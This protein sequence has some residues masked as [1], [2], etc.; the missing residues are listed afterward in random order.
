MLGR[1][2]ELSLLNPR[3][4]EPPS[5]SLSWRQAL[6]RSAEEQFHRAD[7]ASTPR[8]HPIIITS[9]FVAT[10]DSMCHL[11][12]CVCVSMCHCSGKFVLCV[13]NKYVCLHIKTYMKI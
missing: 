3:V 11:S 4:K 5:S 12:V 10:V 13:H 9:T 1:Q 2:A 6:T 7:V 8:S